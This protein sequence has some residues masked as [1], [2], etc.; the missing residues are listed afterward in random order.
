M[1]AY[2]GTILP[3]AF[4]YAPQGWMKCEG[5]TLAISQFSALYALIG[6]TYG[7]NGSS[8]FMLPDLRG[9]TIVGAG[10]GMG[11]TPIQQ[12]QQVG[13]NNTTVSINGAVQV[14][15]GTGNLP[16]HTHGVTVPASGFTAASTL[17]ATTGGPGTPTPSEGASLGASGTG[18][19]SANI[20]VS[21]GAAP[22]TALNTGSVTT[23]LSGQA[24]VTSDPN[25]GT[26]A[27]IVAPINGS[28]NPSVMQP[29]LGLT[30]IICI[31]G[32]FPPRN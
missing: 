32:I 24:T 3:V 31:S 4:N 26:G 16:K 20:Y 30:Y 12:G 8:T 27:P 22:A 2:I 9:R 15:I 21:G 28:A 7:G 10:Q 29:S 18:P 25:D 13:S 17:N 23:Q 19:G 1:E 5:Q 14:T 6:V 11:I